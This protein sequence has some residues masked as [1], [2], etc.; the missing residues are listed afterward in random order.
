MLAGCLWVCCVWCGFLLERLVVG[1]LCSLLL[2]VVFVGLVVFTSELLLSCSLCWLL[3][4]VLLYCCAD[5]GWVAVAWVV[6]SVG[7][8]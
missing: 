5:Y 3:L 4:V 6:N 8:S 1:G 2:G 7:I